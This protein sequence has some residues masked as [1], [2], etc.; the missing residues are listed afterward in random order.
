MPTQ[1]AIYCRISSDPDGLALGV[2]RQETLCRSEAERRGWAVVEVYVDNDMS[3]YSGKPRPAYDRMLEDLRQGLRD[4]VLVVDTDRLTRQPKELEEFIDV[5]DAHGIAL[6][7]VSGEMD[8]ST[9]DGRF[10]ARILGAVARQESEKKS[11]RIMRQRDQMAVKGLPHPKARSFGFESDGM[12]HRD[13]EASLIRKAARDVLAGVS[14]GNVARE[15][16]ELGVTT[17]TGRKWNLR[18]VSLLLNQPRIAGY[19]VHRGE[20]IGD[21]QWEPIVDQVTWEQLQ[22]LFKSRKRGPGRPPRHL[23]SGILVCGRCEGAMRASGSKG[24]P[25]YSCQKDA[26]RGTCG[27]LSVHRG[28]A[29]GEIRE[30][31]LATVT[32]AGGLAKAVGFLSSSGEETAKLTAQLERDRL[33]LE[34]LASDYYDEGLIGR[35]EFFGNRDRLERRIQTTSRALE[36]ASGTIPDIPADY[37]GASRW[38]DEVDNDQRRVLVEVLIERIVVRPLDASKPRRFDPERLE[39]VWKL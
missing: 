35:A 7:N 9:S 5:A 14:M 6:A 16:N 26:S 20:I 15:W 2:E 25:I 3:A 30:Q 23:L 36:R 18:S 33:M 28:H 37:A 38:W 34:Q 8:L 21:G 32:H 13:I 39:P 10:R 27:R 12:T 29:D 24:H 17:A 1:A 19:R 4:G 11:E 31:V 22:A